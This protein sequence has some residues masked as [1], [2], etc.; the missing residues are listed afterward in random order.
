MNIKDKKYIYEKL[1]NL[2]ERGII[3]YLKTDKIHPEPEE[4]Q[5]WY[6]FDMHQA[7]FEAVVGFYFKD[8]DLVG[9]IEYDDRENLKDEPKYK[10]IHFSTHLEFVHAAQTI[11]GEYIFD[12]THIIGG[13]EYSFL[14]SVP[15]RTDGEPEKQIKNSIFI[16]EIKNKSAKN[17]E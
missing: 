1:Q 4:H 15:K 6:S 16:A 14:Y 3:S 9:F 13:K 8:K 12:E 7:D 11:W 17:S 2:E 5:I 10:T